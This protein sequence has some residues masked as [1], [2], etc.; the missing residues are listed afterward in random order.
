MKLGLE[1]RPTYE[2]TNF[3]EMGE[4]LSWYPDG[5]VGYWHDTGH[6]EAQAA[7]GMTPHADWLRA[8]RH[9]IIGI[10]LHDVLGLAVHKAP[11]QGSVDWA[12]LASL[13]P[14]SAIR[15]VEVN[16]TVSEDALRAGI[17]HLRATGWME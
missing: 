7:I 10:H 11:G 5:A 1:N 15:T 14:V 8:Y 4:I 12:G 3:A 6:A 2:I 9:R 13:V 17:A 16:K